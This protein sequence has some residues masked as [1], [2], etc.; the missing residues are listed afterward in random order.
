MFSSDSA[1]ARKYLVSI[2]N[3]ISA[4]RFVKFNLGNS[5]SLSQLHSNFKPIKQRY[6]L[7]LFVVAW[8]ICNEVLS[9]VL[10]DNLKNEVYK[11]DSDSIGIP[12]MSNLF[13]GINVGVFCLIGLLLPKT[14]FWGLLSVASLGIGFLLTLGGALFWM[15]PNHYIASLGH[16][17]PL[18][19]CSYMLWSA[20]TKRRFQLLANEST[21]QS[22]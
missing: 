20:W 1:D 22:S 10:F 19:V 11:S 8:L 7:L 2:K 3:A 13:I 18:T 14:K 12:M 21:K 17:V 15:H 5:V 9:R 16:L 6:Q 4:L